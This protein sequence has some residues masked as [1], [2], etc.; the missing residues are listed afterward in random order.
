MKTEP[1]FPS[2]MIKEEIDENSSS[3]QEF[4]NKRFSNDNIDTKY[5]SVHDDE[6]VTDEE[7]NE[8]GSKRLEFN[9]KMPLSIDIAAVE[10]DDENQNMIIYDS[11]SKPIDNNISDMHNASDEDEYEDEMGS[12]YNPWINAS[13]KHRSPFGEYK[14]R[15]IINTDSMDSGGIKMLKPSGK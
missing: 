10:S 13:E 11:K 15:L 6:E 7:F 4:R 9:P 5:E 14:K 12:K 1:A 2:S 8:N 3:N